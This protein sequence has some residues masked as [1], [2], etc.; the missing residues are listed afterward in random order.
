MQTFDPTQILFDSISNLTGGLVTDLQSLFIC[1]LV[2]V[3]IWN[4]IDLILTGMGAVMNRYSMNRNYEKAE[5]Y[6]DARN[7]SPRGTASYD[8]YNLKYRNALRKSV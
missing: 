4:G 3:F 7:K 5:G 1:V 2:I 6:L 8:Y